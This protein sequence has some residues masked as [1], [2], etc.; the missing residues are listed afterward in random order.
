MMKEIR[1]EGRQFARYHVTSLGIEWEVGRKR[2][3]KKSTLFYITGASFTDDRRVKSVRYNK[4]SGR[5]GRFSERMAKKI[6][7]EMGHALNL[8]IIEAL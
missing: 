6:V 7:A 8:T 5:A 1:K 2:E 3:T 4:E